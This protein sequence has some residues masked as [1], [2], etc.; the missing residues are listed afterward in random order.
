VLLISADNVFILNT[1]AFGHQLR[2]GTAQAELLADVHQL[3][4]QAVEIRNEFLSGNDSELVQIRDEAKHQQLEV[5]YSVNAPLFVQRE[6]N[7]R[8]GQYIAEMHQLGASHLKLNFG[9][10]PK[11]EMLILSDLG[12]Y[13]DGSF[14]FNV[15]NNQ[16]PS[17]SKLKDIVNF[18]TAI[19]HSNVDVGFC[20]DTANWY[21]T[22]NTPEEAAKL[23]SKST[24]YLHLKNKMGEAGS[25][26]VTP[27]VQ[28]DID[29]EKL[30]GFFSNI[31]EFALEYDGT[32]AEI[33]QGL[34][35]LKS[36]SLN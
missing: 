12:K 6:I 27:L 29:W 36:E 3:G 26:Q 32:K 20:F 30:I 5:Y 2:S 34:H 14:E 16:T 21:W 31:H 22:G 19:D 11:D 15:E 10:Y 13:L 25:L 24:R 18:F 4:F 17:E 23:L 9:E 1:I 8:F 33:Q 7:P 35:A 28:G